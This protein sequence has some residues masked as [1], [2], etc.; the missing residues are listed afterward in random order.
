MR[1]I[2]LFSGDPS[3][4][5]VEICLKFVESKDFQSINFDEI[6]IDI[7]GNYYIFKKYIE[8]FCPSLKI[9]K[10]TNQI[11]IYH[12]T[13]QKKWM[14]LNVELS[15]EKLDLSQDNFLEKLLKVS[16]KY[17]YHFLLEASKYLEQKK[18]HA[19]VTAPLHKERIS[20]Q[21]DIDFRGYTSFFKKR[22]CAEKCFMTFTSDFFDLVLLT[23]HIPLQKVSDAITS[24]KIQLALTY[25]EHLQKNNGSQLPIAFMGLNPHASENGHI[26]KEDLFIKKEIDIYQQKNNSFQIDGPL[27]ADSAFIQVAKK[28]YR[29]V[30]CCYHDQGLIPLKM[31]SDFNAVNVS[32]GLPFIRTSPAHGT[33]DNIAWQGHRCQSESFFAAI[34]EAIIQLKNN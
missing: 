22:F 14:F 8:L 19:I 1:K 11:F 5:G 24:E 29:T 33:A 7:L 17:S 20:K 21:N 26:G 12:S 30:I 16:G 18:Y 34:K 4:I 28:K 9:V 6:Q 3:G 25:A 10:E 15:T 27:S 23:S 32:L 31:I 2:L 13:F